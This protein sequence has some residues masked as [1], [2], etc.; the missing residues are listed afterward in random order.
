MENLST[1]TKI[2]AGAIVATIILGIILF[3]ML[4]GH[5]N[6]TEL[7]IKQ[8]P[9]GSMSCVEG[10]GWYVKGF[11]DIYVYER[12]KA[13]YFNSSTE[14]VRGE[15]WEGDDTDEDDVDVTLSRNA[16]ASMSGYVLYELPTE[17]DKL[18]ALHRIYGSSKN[19]KHNLVR[20]EVLSAVRKT[21]PLYTAEEAKVTKFAEMNRMFNDQVVEGEYLTQTNVIKEPT[22]PDELDSNGKVIK[23]A[24]YQEYTI[25]KLK[26]DTNGRRI[27]LKPS[28]LT[29]AGIQITQCVIQKVKLDK[30]AQ[31]Q[32]DV[33]KKREMERVSKA[34]EAEAAKQEA[35]T[36]RE[37]GKADVAREQAAQ[38]VEKI[39][40]T[41]IAEKEK[42]VAVLEA[43]KDFEVAQYE[44]KKANEVAKKIK[45]EKEAEA[46]ANMALVRAGLTP[47][48]RAEWE[49]KT[50]VGVAQALA[51]SAHPLVPEIM[52]NGGDSKNG[53]AM[54]AVG[55]NMLMEITNKLSAK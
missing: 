15:G 36:A 6:S 40:A 1:K 3:N 21:A 35:I 38:L 30:I 53:T 18:L 55:L 28:A 45:A 12:A 52:M 29:K 31:D 44:A 43:Q 41:T 23:K 24:E 46:A 50:K 27:I 37:K 42:E 8:S 47:Q 17:C 34:T 14:K 39:K 33:V 5:K 13:F 22:G 48:E 4:I 7:I 51:N 25:T 16:G 10:Q 19:I 32:L 2:L 26:L 54:D 11:A 20:N 49:Y 9:L